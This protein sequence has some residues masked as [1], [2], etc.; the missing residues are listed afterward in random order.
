MK[1][2]IAD[3]HGECLSSQESL[4]RVGPVAA[5][6][7]VDAAALSKRHSVSDDDGGLIPRCEVPK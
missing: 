2:D 3:S 6:R 5:E 7:Q 1:A 4:A